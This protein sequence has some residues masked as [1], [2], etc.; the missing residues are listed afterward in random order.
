MRRVERAAA[1][2]LFA[3]VAI[4]QEQMRDRGQDQRC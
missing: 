1:R 3:L 4:R 2:D